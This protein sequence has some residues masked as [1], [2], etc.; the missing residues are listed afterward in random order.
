[1]MKAASDGQFLLGQCSRS[2]V[3]TLSLVFCHLTRLHRTVLLEYFSLLL[4]CIQKV[5][6]AQGRVCQDHSLC[7]ESLALRK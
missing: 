2:H 6:A 7:R 3:L 1:M 4:S 5:S